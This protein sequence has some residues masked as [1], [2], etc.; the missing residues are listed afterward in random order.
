MYLYTKTSAFTFIC[1]HILNMHNIGLYRRFRGIDKVGTK[2][3]SLTDF[4]KALKNMNSSLSDGELRVMFEHFDEEDCGLIDYELFIE[5][6]LSIYM[7][8]NI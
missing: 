3:I 6:I 7:Y 4:K 2:V 8:V 1:T 5:G